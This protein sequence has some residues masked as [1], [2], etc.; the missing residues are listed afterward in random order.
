MSGRLVGQLGAGSLRAALA[1]KAHLCST[2]PPAHQ[3]AGPGLFTELGRA[4]VEGST[5]GLPR[6]GLR[7]GT[8]SFLRRNSGCLINISSFFY[9]K[10]SLASF[11]EFLLLLQLLEIWLLQSFIQHILFIEHHL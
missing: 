2:S 5:R 10:E 4:R 11:L 6:P 3:Q 9:W 8:V 7:M 1:G